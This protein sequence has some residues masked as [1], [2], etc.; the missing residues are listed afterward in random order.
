M[1]KRPVGATFVM[2][3][4]TV[5][6]NGSEGHGAGRI[7]DRY[8]R[9]RATDTVDRGSGGQKGGN[10]RPHRRLYVNCP[11]TISRLIY[12]TIKLF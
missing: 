6:H 8:D 9:Q 12:A 2:Q 3:S 4:V 7:Y 10:E 5:N 1:I 11:Q